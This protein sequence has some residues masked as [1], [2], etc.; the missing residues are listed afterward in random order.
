MEI[1]GS[2]GVSISCFEQR[3]ASIIGNV[4]GLEGSKLLS[5]ARAL[6]RDKVQLCDWL[7]CLARAPGTQVHRQFIE[8]PGQNVEDF[9][10][11]ILPSTDLVRSSTNTGP[12]K[13]VRSV[14]SQDVLKMLD[15]AWGLAQS[16]K[17]HTIDEN[18]LTLAFLKTAEGGLHKAIELW[19]G[20]P[21]QLQ[22]FE[23]SLQ[24]TI[25]GSR[26]IPVFGKD[27]SL[28]TS[29]LSTSGRRLLS[30]IAEDAA[31]IRAKKITTRHVL[32]TLLGNESNSLCAALSVNGIDIKK[33]LHAVLARELTQ[34]GR[35]RAPEFRLSADTLLSTISELLETAQ[36][37]ALE[38]GTESVGEIDIARSL[39]ELYPE[40]IARLLPPSKVL[41]MSLI[42][43]YLFDSA[44]EGEDE[45]V[46]PRYSTSEIEKGIKDRIIGQDLAIDRVLPW[47]KR[48]RFGLPRDGRPAGVF[49]FM[50]PTGTG[51]TQMA[52][53]LA[54]YVFGD[55]EMLLFL[56][57]GQFQTRESMNS[58]VGAPP[59]YVG[60]GEG[61][62]TNG[63]RDKP[64]SVVLFDEIEKADT[65]VLHTLL[66]FADEGIIA[67][68]AG[69]VRDGHRC[70]IVM[71]TNA[72][73]D[74]LRD[75]LLEN[76]EAAEDPDTLAGKLSAAGL[77]ELRT[78][79]F[80]PEFLGRVDERI[81]FLPFTE[82]SCRKIVDGVI[83]KERR[84]IKTL[85]D[86]EIVVPEE[87]RQ[88]LA[89]VAFHRSRDEG[90]RGA[91]RA[92]NE[93]VITPAIDVVT[94]FEEKHGRLPKKVQ[95]C[96]LGTGSET[97]VV[98]TP[99]D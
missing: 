9:V 89:G 64:E 75:H 34:P 45:L 57:M 80:R 54:R 68:P 98:V 95:T 1:I 3:L 8:R 44:A 59:G 52:K 96:T 37:F 58:F 12:T 6:G 28:E 15:M 48:L 11:T 4:R 66:R 81:T 30:R 90:A 17:T 36:R 51:K 27:G 19:S 14:V 61:L 46:V 2:A 85:K 56:E 41:D 83:E 88:F 21:E 67:D 62:L 91:P 23:R 69:P 25:R 74:W 42:R 5:Q 65:Q 72:G 93:H 22:T 20:G 49:L 71:T 38:S 84:Q 24:A 99:V 87:V 63:L 97:R 47:I 76:P 26:V 82:S 43:R 60:Y 35:K 10:R 16:S 7:F 77:Q 53:E 29:Y 55:E 18:I 78:K 32:Y 13:L 31:S 86:V 94:D 92:V 33:E 50:G 73:G 79:R 39:V 70:I 40:E